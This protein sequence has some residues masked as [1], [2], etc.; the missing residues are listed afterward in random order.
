MLQMGLRRGL[1]PR[2]IVTTTPKPISLLR[3]LVKSDDT[4]VTRG[5]THENYENLSEQ[6]IRSVIKPYEGTRLGRQELYAEILD[7]VEGALWRRD[8]IERHRVKSVNHRDLQ[9]IVIAIDPAVTAHADSDET[10]M[11]AAARGVDNRGYVLDDLSARISADQWARRAVM[12]LGSIRGDKIVAEVNNGGDLVEKM[13]RGI[14]ARVP[15]KAVHASRGKITR[16]EPIAAMYERGEVSH[17]GTFAAL[18]DEL[19]S[20]T[21]KPGELSPNR[22]DALVW[23]MSEL[24]VETQPVKPKARW[25]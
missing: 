13:L 22:L 8:W 15:Y 17:V 16:A 5:T 10:G 14:D 20:Y 6:F 7:D 4:V 3:Q 21:G 9:R 11:V 12:A 18:E 19:C 23:A 2:Q 24:F 25:L 1:N